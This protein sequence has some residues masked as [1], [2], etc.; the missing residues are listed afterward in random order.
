MRWNNNGVS[1]RRG[2]YEVLIA[3]FDGVGHWYC[4]IPMMTQQ[5]MKRCFKDLG[6]HLGAKSVE[7]KYLYDENEN[8]TVTETMDFMK[9]YD[10]SY[11]FKKCKDYN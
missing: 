7:V 11:K 1:Y 5:S 4:N 8:A 9:L 2:C 6:E 3:Q 10:G